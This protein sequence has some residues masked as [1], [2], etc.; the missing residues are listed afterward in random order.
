MRRKTLELHLQQRH[1]VP[2]VCIMN[3]YINCSQIMN[4]TLYLGIE[5]EGTI[6][7]CVVFV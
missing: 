5:S 7:I 2:G 3:I 4:A 1:R 6:I